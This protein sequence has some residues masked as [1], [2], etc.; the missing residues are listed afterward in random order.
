GLLTAVAVLA[1]VIEQALVDYPES[2]AGLFTGLVLASILI[3]RRDVAWTRLRATTVVFVG[4]VLF[5]VLG[6]KGAPV[7]DPSPVVLFASGAVAICAMVLPGISGSFLLLMVGMYGTMIQVVDDRMVADAAVFGAGAIVGLACFSTLLARLLARRHD[8]VLAVMVGLLVG[9][10]RVL[11]PWPHGVGVISRHAEGAVAG[12]ALGWPEAAGGLV[13]P[14]LL[15][16]LSLVV[17][18]AVDRLARGRLQA[19]D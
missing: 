5:A 1:G 4:I 14:T 10:L 13:G 9:S 17:V 6:L 16:T 8:D 11:W 3:A 2:M 19:G 12:T 15:A 18:L 7:I